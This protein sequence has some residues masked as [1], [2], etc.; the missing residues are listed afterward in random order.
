MKKLSVRDQADVLSSNVDLSFFIKNS[1]TTG[2]HY[3][4]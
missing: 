3:E 1:L 4:F 2:I